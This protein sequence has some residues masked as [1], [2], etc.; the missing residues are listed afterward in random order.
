VTDSEREWGME[1]E[2]ATLSV[3]Q[4]PFHVSLTS[5]TLIAL[6][7][8]LL[9]RFKSAVHLVWIRMFQSSSWVFPSPIQT[10]AWEAMPPVCSGRNKPHREQAPK[11][12][13]P[14]QDRLERSTTSK[15]SKQ[16]S[17]AGHFKHHLG[18]LLT[19]W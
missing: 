13:I 4:R 1:G 15:L 18:E 12:Q 17:E 16:D 5:S 6:L 19:R 8:C 2:G 9:S 14:K 7:S 11:L 3:G 10:F